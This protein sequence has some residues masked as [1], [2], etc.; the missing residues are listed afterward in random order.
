[1][2]DELAETGGTFFLQITDV[3]KFLLEVALF[4][5]EDSLIF[6]IDSF[7]IPDS[8]LKRVLVLYNGLGC[9]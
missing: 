5:V 9:G 2:V 6:Y 8:S 4:T 7:P 1:M 3:L